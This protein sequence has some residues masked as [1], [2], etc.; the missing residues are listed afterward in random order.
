MITIQLG[1]NNLSGYDEN[2]QSLATDNIVIHPLFDPV[3]FQNDI[4]LV[5]FR[6]AVTLTGILKQ[7]V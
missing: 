6:L 7:V 5:M 2:R 4:G 1:S 3:T